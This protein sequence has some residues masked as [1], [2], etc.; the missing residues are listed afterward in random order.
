MKFVLVLVSLVLG[1]F[2]TEVALR[3]FFHYKTDYDMEMWKYAKE[4]KIPVNDLR[5]HV[6]KPNSKAQI[7]RVEIRINSMGFRG[8]E[9]NPDA[10]SILVIGDSFTLGFGVP[11][12][13]TFASLLEQK[14]NIQVINSGVGNYNLEQEL[15]FWKIT[16]KKLNPKHVIWALYVNDGELTQ[17]Y[18]LNSL[19][20]N[21]YIF[22]FLS[23]IG[24]KLNT[25]FNNQL[26]YTHTY[27]SLYNDK[28]WPTFQSKLEILAKE[29]SLNSH[30]LTVVLLSDLRNLKSYAFNDFHV[31]VQSFLKQKHIQVIDTLPVFLNK[32]EPSLWVAPDDPHPNILGHSLIAEL[33]YREIKL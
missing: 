17:K 7:M 13:K 25:L 10:P 21:C 16:G 23:S 32:P 28:N 26:D 19:T 3:I 8:K 30:Q 12:D 27:Q 4:L 5:S 11:E 15:E 9:I 29:F 18:F 33:L 1:L 31:K 22:A 6:H 2:F 20:A 14:L 24:I